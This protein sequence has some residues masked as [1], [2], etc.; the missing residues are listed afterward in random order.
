MKNFEIETTEVWRKIP[1]TGGLYEMR[2]SDGAIRHTGYIG[3]LSR[4]RKHKG[5][6][7]GNGAKCQIAMPGKKIDRSWDA[8]YEMTW[9]SKARAEYWVKYPDKSYHLEMSN[10]GRVRREKGYGNGEMLTVNEKTG[11]IQVWIQAERKNK[12]LKYEYVYNLLFGEEDA[13]VKKAEEAAKASGIDFEAVKYL[14]DILTG[15]T[16]E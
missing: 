2:K 16:K 14:L 4:K 7:H 9:G 15:K 1:I 12:Q 13:Y 5:G 6:K 3:N 11:V 8:V 10:Y